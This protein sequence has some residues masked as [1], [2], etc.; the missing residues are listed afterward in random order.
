ML[1][2]Q[3]GDVHHRQSSGKTALMTAASRGDVAVVDVLLRH[4]AR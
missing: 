3:G 2:Q 4:G 1:L